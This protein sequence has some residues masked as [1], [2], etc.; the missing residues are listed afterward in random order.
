MM[1]KAAKFF[2]L[3]LATCAMF[4]GAADARCHVPNLVRCLDSACV[5][6]L[7]GDPTVRCALCGSGQATL[8][9]Q[10]LA[11]RPSA[12][13]LDTRN[14]PTDPRERYVWAATEC[15]RLIADCTAD[16]VRDNYNTLIMQ[17]CNAALVERTGADASRTAMA[18]T[19]GDQCSQADLRRCVT[20]R[21]GAN[22]AACMVDA[23][24]DRHFSACTITTN[25]GSDQNIA[26]IRTAMRTE[27]DNFETNRT[28]NAETVARRHRADREEWVRA[29]G[30]DCMTGGGARAPARVACET[31]KCNIIGGCQG[32]VDNT[33]IARLLCEHVDI[34]CGRIRNEI[35]P[36]A[37]AP[38]RHTR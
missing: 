15:M 19:P 8:R 20:E 32:S 30:T 24:L 27:R 38:V 2:A 7:T 13:T 6:G 23:D 17:S 3:C 9:R 5:A 36:T 11:Q 16:D 34:A 18:Q 21:C 37:P 14:A 28:A 31:E 26:N 35:A 33:R 25:C 4:I 10:P 1:K 22:W 29:I 12:T